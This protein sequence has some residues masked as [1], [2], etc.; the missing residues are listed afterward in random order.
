MVRNRSIQVRLTRL[1]YDRICE[2]TEAQ[3]FNSLSAYIRFKALRQDF[4]LF[5][6]VSDIHTH[7]LGEKTAGRR[8]RN[9]GELPPF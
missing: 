5:E 7:L 9:A 2:N 4:G 8:K 1:Q 6:K 3:G